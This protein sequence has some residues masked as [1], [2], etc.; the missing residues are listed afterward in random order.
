MR[1]GVVEPDVA[2]GG[3][4][5]PEV[6]SPPGAACRQAWAKKDASTSAS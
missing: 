5:P 4:V 6:A 2:A 3:C 1:S